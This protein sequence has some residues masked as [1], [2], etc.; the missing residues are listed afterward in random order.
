MISDAKNNFPSNTNKIRWL[1]TIPGVLPLALLLF[2]SLSLAE[3]VRDDFSVGSYGNNDGTANWSANWIEDDVAGTGPASGNVFITGGELSFDDQPNTN[4]QPSLAREANLAGASSATLNFDWRT[5]NG[6][7]NSD[8]FIVEIS[9]DGGTNW[10]TLENFT[11]I[12]GTSNG[13]RAFDITAYVAANTQ[14]RFRVNNNYGGGNE[15]F[16]VDY[17]EIDY[18]VILSGTDLAVT[19]TDTPDPV[20]VTNPL[21]Y[22]LTVTNNGPDDATGVT[23]VDVLPAGATFQSASASQG[24]CVHVAGTVTCTMGNLLATTGASINVVL[25]APFTTGT[26]TNTATVSGNEVDPIAA[27]DTSGEDT[28]VQNLNINQLCYLVADGNNLFTRVDTADFNPA[29]NETNIGTG[30]GVGNIEAIAYNSATGVVYAANGG[31]L[32]VLNTTTGL[33]QPLPQTFG[34]GGGSLGSITFSDVDGLTYDATLGILFGSHARGG[35]DLLFQIDMTMG[36]HVQNAFGLN[37]DYVEIQPVLGN[38][39]VDDIAVDPTTGVMY[40]TTNN[41]GSTDRL[42]SINKST[43]ATTH[44]SLITVPDIEGLGTD[45]TGQL[46]GTSGT[47]GIL[48]E[49][50]KVTGVGTNGRT[51]NNGTDYEAV[52]CYAVSPTVS[53]DLALTKIVNDAAPKEGD[54]V[55]Y[56]VTVTNTGPGPATV[57][58]VMDL[59]PAGVTFVSAVPG[60]GTYDALSGDWFVGNLAAGSSVGLLLQADVDAGTGGSTI[61]NTVTIDFLSQIDTNA[62]NDI[63]SVDIVPQGSPSLLVL[64]TA[65]IIED[66]INGI[67]NP[68]AIPGGTIRYLIAATNTGTG[69]A[70]TNSLNVTDMIPV[71]TALRVTDFD[72]VTTGPVLLVDGT[73]T[74][75]LTYSFTTLADPADDVLFSNDGGLTFTYSPVVSANGTDPAV[76]HIRVNPKGI[77]AADSGSGSPG[78][79]VFFKAIIQ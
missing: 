49:I 2:S 48:Y 44:I 39:I 47:Q 73:P 59:L 72:L 7:D 66:P 76:T 74:S 18:T 40:A 69:A 56:T 64:K 29:T 23:V 36:A 3:T 43:G 68:K 17:I 50:N 54:T 51:I 77:F 45:P 33:F 52:D 63:A 70:D 37:I 9:A 6:V 75:G 5:T 11:G 31:Q 1:H 13:S 71:N 41:G 38:T 15:F 67:A 35:N 65:T 16:I 8:S 79:Q 61:T 32:G 78:F 57:V 4:T 14:V 25:T 42:A 28:L 26:I 24:G 19:Q 53:A 27:N 12:N 55:S 22:T 62:S 34:T 20:N 46:W 60:Q 21:S 58:Q 30:T 10:T